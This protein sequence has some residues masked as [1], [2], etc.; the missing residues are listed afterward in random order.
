MDTNFNEAPGLNLPAPT[1]E[2]AGYNFGAANSSASP[3][4]KLPV[5]DHNFSAQPSTLPAAAAVPLP[6]APPLAVPSTAVAPT[7]TA[8]AA[9]D[10]NTDAID[11]EWISKAKAIVEKTRSDPYLESR[12]LGK[13]KAD[14]LKTRYNKHIK[15]AEERQ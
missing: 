3:E 9:D 12:E 1:S 13:V 15:V 10:D 11:Q 4:V 5:A 6:Q 14:Y 8:I 7:A 2:S